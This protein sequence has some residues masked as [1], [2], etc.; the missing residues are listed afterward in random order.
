MGSDVTYNFWRFRDAD[1]V[2]CKLFVSN[3]LTIRDGKL[4]FRFTGQFEPITEEDF[5]A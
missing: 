1:G 2:M 3:P 5:F 4:F